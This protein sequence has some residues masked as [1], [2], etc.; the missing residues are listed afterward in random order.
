MKDIVGAVNVQLDVCPTACI[1]VEM[2]ANSRIKPPIHEVVSDLLKKT[3]S[4]KPLGRPYFK[5]ATRFDET[6]TTAVA[7]A[8]VKKMER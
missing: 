2:P 7:I 8:V 3:E 6:P 5:K 4:L 1:F